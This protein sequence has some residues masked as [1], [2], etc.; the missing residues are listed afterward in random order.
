MQTVSSSVKEEFL[1][2]WIKGL[3]KYDACKSEM[4]IT[5]RKNA[6]KLSANVAMASTTTSTR[7]W[8]RAI[9]RRSVMA[10]V[11]S[12]AGEMKKI[13][14]RRCLMKRIRRRRPM[15]GKRAASKYKAAARVVKKR[16]AVLKGLIP[17]GECMEDDNTLIK[18]TL[19][20]ILALRLQVD[21]MR[22]L[23]SSTTSS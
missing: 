8:P 19:D 14:R 1:K 13:R 5:E 2:K 20:Y 15:A 7:Q 11:K 17:G 21:V 16:S 12:G 4:S 9:W 10:A 18:E 6:I 22:H 3:Q 23:A